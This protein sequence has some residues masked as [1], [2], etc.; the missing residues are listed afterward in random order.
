[1]TIPF[2]I[3][4]CIIV[5]NARYTIKECLDSLKDFDEVILLD[6]GSSDDT[7]TIAREFC[8]VRIFESEFIGFGALKNLALSYA[9]ND[10]ILSLDSD[11]VLE[12]NTIEYLKN[13]TL[14]A[15]NIYAISRKNLY[16]GEWIKAC[17]WYP[18]YVYRIFN[19]THTRFNDNI[20]HE[21]VMIQKDSTI[22]KIPMHNGAI[23]HYAYDNIAHLLE[24]MQ[25][26]SSLWAEQNTHKQSSPLKAIFRGLWSFIRSYFFKKGFI[27]GYRGF[28]ISVCNGLGT[29]FK[30]MKLYEINNSTPPLFLRLSSLLTIKKKD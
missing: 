8:N 16:N 1:M 11:E 18:D 29:F 14:D 26:Y 5:K 10:W 25:Y 4:V 6:N 3:S 15:N 21:S 28:I 23:K 20:V 7:L 30:Y 12:S 24:K 17:G 9:K 27:Y 19:K 2:N 22:L 13:I